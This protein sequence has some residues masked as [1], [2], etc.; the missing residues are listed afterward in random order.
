MKMT[1]HAGC[2][3]TLIGAAFRTKPNAQSKNKRHVLPRRRGR[4][5]Q[6]LSQDEAHPP[7]R[8]NFQIAAA[9]MPQR[10]RQLS[11]LQVD[12][13]AVGNN[14]CAGAAHGGWVPAHSHTATDPWSLPAH[15]LA[16]SDMSGKAPQIQDVVLVSL[17]DSTEIASLT[18]E[19]SI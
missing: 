4:P 10:R 18:R 2:F 5:F 9:A 8:L 11:A 13:P 3:D 7:L 1:A 14:F 12:D 19:I 16:L 17:A 6:L 15:N